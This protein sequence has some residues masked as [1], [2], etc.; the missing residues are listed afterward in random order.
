MTP[1]AR[2][3]ARLRR[4][5]CRLCRTPVARGVRFCGA[6]YPAEIAQHEEMSR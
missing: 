4:S 6:H 1:L 2:L 3:A 5:R